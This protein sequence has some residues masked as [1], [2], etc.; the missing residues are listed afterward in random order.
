METW[1]HQ[2]S[3]VTSS[4]RGPGRRHRGGG[5]P[6]PGGELAGRP[7]RPPDTSTRTRPP[8]STARERPGGH[9][10]RPHLLED[11]LRLTS[12]SR[13]GRRV[14]LRTRDGPAGRGP[15]GGVGH[16]P[17]GRRPPN[18]TLAS[19]ETSGASRRWPRSASGCTR[20]PG[21]GN[22]RAAGQVPGRRAVVR[23]P[24][25]RQKW[26]WPPGRSGRPVRFLVALVAVTVV[27]AVVPA[28]RLPDVTEL[29]RRTLRRLRADTSR[30]PARPLPPRPS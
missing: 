1:G 28:L 7:R 19:V 12:T 2:K 15:P 24:A 8:S 9:H 14:E 17:A 11:G 25:G 13:R 30:P 29:G 22:P 18:R 26:R 27:V 20:R 3:P 21:S 23:H 5:G 10:R 16:L 6:G 4:L